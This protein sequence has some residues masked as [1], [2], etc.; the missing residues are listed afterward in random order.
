MS[1]SGCDCAQ[2]GIPLEHEVHNSLCIVRGYVI[3]GY[4]LESARLIARSVKLLEHRSV[5]RRWKRVLW[6]HEAM[7]GGVE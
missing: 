5:S 4:V 3:S 1:E 6:R 7:D 2:R